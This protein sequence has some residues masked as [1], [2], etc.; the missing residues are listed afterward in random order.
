[1]PTVLYICTYIISM[2][3][4]PV[5]S[6]SLTRG[7]SKWM[8]LCA[9]NR[10]RTDLWELLCLSAGPTSKALPSPKDQNHEVTCLRS[11]G[12]EEVNLGLRTRPL[13]CQSKQTSL[14]P[15]ITPNA[16]CASTC[17]SPLG[18]SRQTQTSRCW[19]LESPWSR[20]SCETTWSGPAKA[21]IGWTQNSVS[22]Q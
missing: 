9:S 14:L 16:G 13:N 19:R 22:L 18:L 21:T 1:M 12:Q 3:L 7:L 10:H 20:G 4:I 15:L 8:L 11:L 6:V 2:Q 5:H 17:L